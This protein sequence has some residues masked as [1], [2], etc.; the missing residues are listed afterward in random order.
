MTDPIAISVSIL[1]LAVSAVTAWLTLFRR[2]TIKMTQ[3]TIIY[4]GF[5]LPRGEDAA[6]AKVYFRT[7]LF[8]TSKRGRIIESMHIA[9]S[10]AE[11]KQNFNIWVHGKREELVR[12]SGLFVGENGVAANH[13]FLLPEDGGSFAWLPGAY[14]VQVYARLLGD[15]VPRLL[16]SQR[17]E[18]THGTSAEL[19]DPRAGVYFDWAS[20]ASQYSA[21][22]ARRPPAVSPERFLEALGLARP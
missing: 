2:G 1:A 16:F 21:H 5:D 20:D 3:P 18:I 10:R 14:Q 22:V 7:L 13:H 6:K 15:R 11:S 17:L 9:I 8:S 12:G 19:K 4:F